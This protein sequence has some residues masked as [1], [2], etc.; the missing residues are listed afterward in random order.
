[1]HSQ[2]VAVLAALGCCKRQR[3]YPCQAFRTWTEQFRSLGS[4][5]YMPPCPGVAGLLEETGAGGGGIVGIIDGGNA[6]GAGGIGGIDS[7]DGVDGAPIG[8]AVGP[9]RGGN[10]GFGGRMTG[11]GGSGF[12]IT[13]GNIHR[14]VGVR[15]VCDWVIC[16][17]G[18]ILKASAG[19]K[20]GRIVRTGSPLI[21]LWLFHGHL[22]A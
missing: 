6:D 20:Q 11:E 12:G 8:G 9:G 2:C 10:G 14:K 5:L 18:I 13:A 4:N 22:K 21:S 16:K 17:R 7:E 15:K 1:M 19:T 3:T